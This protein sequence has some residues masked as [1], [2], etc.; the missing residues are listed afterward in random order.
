[1]THT[2]KALTVWQPWAW[3]LVAGHKDV[4]NRCWPTRHRGPLLI[5]AG[6]TY[7]GDSE[8]CIN[9]IDIPSGL[10]R[11]VIVGA[12]RLVGCLPHERASS[13]WHQP[14]QYGFYVGDAVQLATPVPYRG[15]QGMFDV[16]VSAVLNLLAWLTVTTKTPSK[17]ATETAAQSE[18]I[19]Q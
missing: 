15:Q 19:P 16:P 17:A 4:E 1:V 5:H 12:V 8:Y 7:D 9:G 13:I 3:L 2:I 18:R 11:W 14:G 10:P 6:K